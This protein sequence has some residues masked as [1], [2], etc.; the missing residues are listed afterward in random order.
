MYTKEQQDQSDVTYCVKLFN[1]WVRA[2]QRPGDCRAQD[3]WIHF[4]NNN[5]SK[6]AREEFDNRA[7][8]ERRR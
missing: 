6:E 4:Y 8:I 7:V 1:R 2:S 5:M 3:A